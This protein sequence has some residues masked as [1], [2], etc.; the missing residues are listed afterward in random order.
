M[1]GGRIFRVRDVEEREYCMCIQWG[2][3]TELHSGVWVAHMLGASMVGLN[4]TLYPI[5]H[6]VNPQSFSASLFTDVLRSINFFR[7]SRALFRPR[8]CFSTGSRR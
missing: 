1:L 8:L 4:V 3:D 7:T 5:M 2:L 6:V